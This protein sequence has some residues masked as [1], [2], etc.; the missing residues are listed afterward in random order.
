M[1]GPA[2]VAPRI[3]SSTDPPMIPSKTIWNTSLPGP[4]L[5]IG[6][7]SGGRNEN[8]P[9]RRSRPDWCSRKIAGVIGIATSARFH[10]GTD[11]G[12]A[13][14]SFDHRVL[15]RKFHL[16]AAGLKPVID[17]ERAC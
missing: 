2:T 15:Q 4:T 9:E 11:L 1:N 3:R 12:R 14:S 16:G 5:S 6:T 13:H 7:V 10:D 17:D 8:R